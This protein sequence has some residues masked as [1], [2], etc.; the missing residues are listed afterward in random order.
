MNTFPVGFRAL[1]IGASGSIGSAFTQLLRANPRC[2]HVE[3]LH[4][5]SLPAIDFDHE[6]SIAQAAAV[7]AEQPKF[8][9]IINAVGVLHSSH[10]MPEKKLSDLN[11]DQMMAT[12]RVN[13]LGPALT[14]RHFSPL[15]DAERGVMAVISAKVGSI[16]DN[17]LGGWYSYRASKAALNMLLKTASIEIKRSKPNAVLVSLH[18]GTVNSKL[19]Q[20]FR[21]AEIGRSAADAA[22]DMLQVMNGLT[23]ADTG[24]FYAYNGA[25]LPW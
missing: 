10:F 12:F 9:L 3:G 18:P 15:L 8:H 24:R 16:E 1:V 19:S 25:L 13:T 2:G 17:R 20:P 21:G 4:R 7:L 5:H 11:Y 22:S 14:L 6:D 23:P